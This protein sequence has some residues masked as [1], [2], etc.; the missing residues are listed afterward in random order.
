MASK[1][2]ARSPSSRRLAGARHRRQRNPARLG[3]DRAFQ[4]LL[5]PVHRAWPGDL[6]AAG[7]LGDAPIHG[8]VL[9]LQAEQPVVGGQHQPAELLSHA[10]ADP[11]IAAAAQGG[12]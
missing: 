12:R 7:R 8:Q 4:P 3:G 6:A 10:G 2:A 9:Q 1:V 5:A 11:L